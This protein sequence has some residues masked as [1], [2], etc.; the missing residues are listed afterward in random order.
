MRC[1]L[2][3]RKV[4]RKQ[5]KKTGNEWNR[6]RYKNEHNYK[7]PSIFQESGSA[8]CRSVLYFSSFVSG[9]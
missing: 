4:R 1:L 2:G 7:Q 5:T 3:S 6:T 9:M 8:S